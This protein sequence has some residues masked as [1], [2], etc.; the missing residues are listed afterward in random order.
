M[1]GGSGLATQQ[2]TPLHL[3]AA[4]PG[5][6]ESAWTAGAERMEAIRAVPESP[7]SH[8]GRRPPLPAPAPERAHAAQTWQL[9]G[10]GAAA[11]WEAE[12]EDVGHFYRHQVTLP[13]IGGR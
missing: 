7:G 10:A 11:A 5:C 4:S 6:L 9:Q 12:H 3:P 2:L 8:R 1:A 13:R